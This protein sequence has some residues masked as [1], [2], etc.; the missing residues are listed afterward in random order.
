MKKLY[1]AFNLIIF[2]IAGYAQSTSNFVFRQG[3]EIRIEL[4]GQSDYFYTHAIQKGHSLYA[5]SKIFKVSLNTLYN[6]NQLEAGATLDIGQK[7]RIPIKDDYLF[8]GVSLDGLKHGHY[9]PVYYNTKP[10]DNLFRISRIYFNQPTEDL[11]KRNSLT[12]NSLALGQNILIGWF[13]I[14]SPKPI[15]VEEEFEEDFDDDLDYPNSEIITNED[16][17]NDNEI[18]AE[19]VNLDSNEI[20]PEFPQGFNTSLLGNLNYSESMKE[21]KQLEVANWDNT[22]PDNGYLYVLHK[23]AIL[24]SYVELFNPNTKISV[25]AKV[26]GRIPYGAY[27]S[28]VC[29]VLSPRTATKLNALDK[30]FKVQIKALVYDSVSE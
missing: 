5:L 23:N 13:P 29:L 22:M 10:K 6:Y 14:D 28:D 1:I 19:L 20:S 24:D 2:C 25:H 12:S 11:V 30:R 21:I 18:K 16:F 27:S 15:I 26:I 17:L 9:I 7:I 4:S 8:K 3:D